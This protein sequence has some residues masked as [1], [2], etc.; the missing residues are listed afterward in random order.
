MKEIQRQVHLKEVKK[1]IFLKAL[2]LFFDGQSSSVM[3]LKG[4][5]LENIGLFRTSTSS[6]C[7]RFSLSG[8]SSSSSSYFR[9]FLLIFEFKFYQL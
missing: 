9:E 1:F 2:G 3:S 7:P 6:E 8:L 5:L 4:I